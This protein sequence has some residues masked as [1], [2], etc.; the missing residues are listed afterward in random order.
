MAVSNGAHDRGLVA[1]RPAVARCRR[2]DLANVEHLP[3]LALVLML[4]ALVMS[5]GDPT[6]GRGAPS[7]ART[8]RRWR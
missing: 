1:E 8:A 5:P 3:L 7:I 2:H 4:F 6:R